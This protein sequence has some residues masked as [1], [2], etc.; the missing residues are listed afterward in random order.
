GQQYEFRVRAVNK[1]GPGEASDSTGPHIARPKNAPPKIDRN[2]M[3][4][5]RVKAGKNVELEVP[6]SGEPPP[7]KK[8]TVD[9]MP[10]PDRWLIT[11]EDYR[12]Q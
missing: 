6:V 12:I 7:N 10:A 5:I 2:Y 9:G 11:S 1:G 4:D 3:R 8:F